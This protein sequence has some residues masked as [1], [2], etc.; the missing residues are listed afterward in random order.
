M[1]KSTKSKSGSTKN[2]PTTAGTTGSVARLS[3]EQV[4]AELAKFPEW[5]LVGD[6]IQRTFGFANFVEAMAFVNKVAAAAEAAQHHPDVLIRYNKVTM[7]LSTHDAH[8][9]SA[10]DFALAST[11]DAMV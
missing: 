7:T 1:A 5:S 4:A 3:D 2:A 6:A 8:G 11:M 9:I 10:K